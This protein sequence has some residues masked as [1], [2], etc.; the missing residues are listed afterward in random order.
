M[1]TTIKAD[2][3]GFDLYLDCVMSL[4]TPGRLGLMDMNG[5]TT[6]ANGVFVTDET[7][8]NKFETANLASTYSVETVT[9]LLNYI[10]EKKP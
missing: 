6:G 3:A 8:Q 4:N 10:E 5:Y 1:F 2:P 9:D 7:L